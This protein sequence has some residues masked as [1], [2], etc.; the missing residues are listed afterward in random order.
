MTTAFAFPFRRAHPLELRR[1]HET[2]SHRSN[3]R[4]VRSGPGRAK[5][6]QVFATPVEIISALQAGEAVVLMDDEDRE[7][8]GDIVVAS[9]FATPRII[10][11]M[12]RFGRGLICITLTEEI[13][14]RLGLQLLKQRNTHEFGTNFTVP[15]DA[16]QGTTTGI[17]ASD[18]ARTVQVA[19]DP[20][21]RP[22][23]LKQ[24][25][26]VFPLMARPG[27]VLERPGHTEAG[28]DYAALAGL[29]PSAV[30]CEIIKDDGEMARLDDL[31][32]FA[33]QHGLKMGTVAD[34]VAYRRAQ[35]LAARAAD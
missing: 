13:C 19:I 9:E 28:C 27:G 14:E 23:D 16:V 25:G 20:A 2:A 5:S 15:I 30:I 7:N 11:F 12:A 29:Q 21:T 17:S 31:K 18:R 22:E 3:I 10:N 8:E 35:E 26:H 24:P 6:D 32:L 1:Y 33:R 34:L 4:A